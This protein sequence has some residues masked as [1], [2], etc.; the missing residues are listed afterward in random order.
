MK[1][2]QP[3]LSI[4][5]RS[6]AFAALMTLNSCDQ[7]ESSGQAEGTDASSVDSAILKPAEWGEISNLHAFGPF[8]L[9]G[10]PQPEDFKQAQKK[11]VKTVINMR[12]ADENKDFDEETIVTELGMKYVHLPWNGPEELT[13]EILDRSRDLLN[14]AEQ[15]ILLHCSSANRVG[16]VWIP[17]RLLDDGASLEQ[18]VKE[19]KMIGI[20][21]PEYEPKAVDYIKRHQQ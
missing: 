19:A 14:T 20:K 2:A 7:T 6:V 4:I 12:H 21:T 11:G 3:S 16:A 13:D 5:A 18:A 1:T 15:P 9:A 10:Q 8:F 17:W